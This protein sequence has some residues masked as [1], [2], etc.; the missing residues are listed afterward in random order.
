M[1]NKGWVKI[2]RSL[3]DKGWYKNS[4]FVHLWIHILMKCNHSDKE[5]WFNGVNVKLKKGQFITGRKVLSAETGI[6]ESKIQRILKCFETEQQIKQQTTNK[7]RVITV[8]NWEKY[9]VDEQQNEQQVNNKRT[10]SE[11]QVNTN[12]NVNNKKNEG[13]YTAHEFLKQNC[14]ITLDHLNTKYRDKINSWAE[15]IEKF[16][17]KVEI[18]QLQYTE[19]IL[20]ARFE[21]MAKNWIKYQDKSEGK[22]KVVLP[23]NWNK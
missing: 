13:E 1:I 9:Q 12:K 16:N 3:Q 5:F 21:L 7:N 4:E 14:S 8:L 23:A 20:L 22:E 19:R 18:E 2:H 10:T 15:F 17:L 6:S 11:Q